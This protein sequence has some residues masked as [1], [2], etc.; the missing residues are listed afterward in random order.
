MKTTKPTP[1]AA[2]RR[3][4]DPELIRQLFERFEQD[5]PEPKTELNF[6]NPFTLTVAVALSAQTTD[7]AVNKAT[8]PLFAIADNP[9]DMLAL[10]E[11]KLMRMISSIGLYRNKA[12]NVMEMCRILLAQYDGDIPLNRAALLSL[13]GVGN[14]TASVV[15]NELDI[16]PAIAVDTHVYRVS[17][18]L[19]L[20]DASAN[21][22]DKVE[23]ALMKAIPKPWLNRA[24]HWLILH[25]RYLCVARKPKC[26]ICI[27]RDLCPKIGVEFTP[28]L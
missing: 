2:K 14:K 11:E 25:G 24:H 22:P 26:E 3:K 19:G 16:E 20:V 15:L 6:V 4:V 5:K 18:R 17:H 28:L 10:G 13:P 7:V 27:V 21:T 12:K 1:K 23:A 8:A 9:A